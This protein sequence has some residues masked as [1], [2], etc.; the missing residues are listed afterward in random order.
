MVRGFSPGVLCG[1]AFAGANLRADDYG[2]RPGVMTAEELAAM[3]L[4]NCELAV[5]SACE[6]HVGLRRGGQSIASLQQALHA[7]GVRTTIASLWNVPDEA[8]RIL[9]AE[10]YRRIWVLEEGNA[11]A[12]WEAKRTIRERTDERGRPVHSTRDWAAWVMM[13]DPE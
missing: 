5:L 11:K 13:G 3:D 1:L 10:F 4:S 8:T 6:T 9:M 12:L 2:H 7:A